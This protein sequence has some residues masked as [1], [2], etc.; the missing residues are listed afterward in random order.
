MHKNIIIITSLLECDSSKTPFSRNERF[1]QTKK[2]IESVNK[3]KNSFIVLIDC[4]SFENHKE[5][6]DYIMKNTNLFIFLK[7]EYSKNIIK[8]CKNKTEG[9]FLYLNTCFKVLKEN[10]YLDEFKNIYKVSGRY[11][12]NDNFDFTKY[13]NDD[14]IIK[15]VDEKIWAGACVS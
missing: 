4:S 14:I 9:E 15:T 13:D 2:T 8:Y 7:D 11:Y 10:G 1:E 12:L 5:Q 6:Y 3:I